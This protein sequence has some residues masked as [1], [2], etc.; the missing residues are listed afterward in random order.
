MLYYHLCKVLAEDLGIDM[1]K[2]KAQ[3]ILYSLSIDRTQKLREKAKK[4]NLPCTL[5]TFNQINDL[6]INGWV[7]ELGKNH[8][9]YAECWVTYFEESPWFR[10]FAPLYCNVIDT[11]NIENFTRCLTHQLTKNV[12][13]GDNTCERV[14]IE[15]D[16]VKSGKF[17]YTL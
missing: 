5:D 11:T 8:C 4:L 12:L 7:K 15:S 6:P 2:E 14:Y 10:E 1:A 16:I 3:K 13:T 17:T 9:P